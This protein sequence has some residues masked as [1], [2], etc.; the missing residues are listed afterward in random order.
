MSDA[1]LLHVEALKH[2]QSLDIQ[3][4]KV[5]DEGVKKL[6]KAL[7]KCDIDSEHI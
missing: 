6:K 5:T 3:H 4:T 7:P 1:G 2:L